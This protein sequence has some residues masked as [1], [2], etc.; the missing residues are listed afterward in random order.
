MGL[1]IREA[2]LEKDGEVLKDIDNL[3]FHRD[4]D[5]PSETIEDEVNYLRGGHTFICYE[6]DKSVGLYSYKETDKE[7]VELKSLA[8]IPEFQNRGIAK[9]MMEDFFSRI[10]GK[11]SF[12]VTHPKNTG[13]IIL[14]LKSGY[15]IT[16]WKENVYGDGEPRLYLERTII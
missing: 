6:G 16:G 4:F 11:K 7:G 3:S 12:L 8:V 5:I 1:S 15:V 13:A 2:N 9:T 10:D 14:Y